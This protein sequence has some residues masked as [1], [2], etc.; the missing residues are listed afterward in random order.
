MAFWNRGKDAEHVPSGI[1][2][3]KIPD[4]IAIIL[5]GNGRWAKKRGLPR[6]AGGRFQL[7]RVSHNIGAVSP[8]CFMVRRSVWQPLDP[9]YHT[10]FAAADACMAMSEKGLRHVFTPHARAICAEPEKLLL[11]TEDR[12]AEDLERFR[13]RWG[14]V[15]DPCWNPGLRDDRGNLSPRRAG[16]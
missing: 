10:A 15:K 3:E 11:L 9:A 6:T 5:D 1:D 13:E 14:E 4:H 7:N 2:P 8:A 16:E 12:D